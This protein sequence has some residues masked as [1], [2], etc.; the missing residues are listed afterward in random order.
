[1]L[2]ER[3][4]VTSYEMRLAESRK[5]APPLEEDALTRALEHER[6][7]RGQP[8]HV[9]RAEMERAVARRLEKGRRGR[10]SER[11]GGPGD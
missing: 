4:G 1:M 2:R 6:K 11:P 3:Y 7:W 10:R 8:E 5:P 9:I